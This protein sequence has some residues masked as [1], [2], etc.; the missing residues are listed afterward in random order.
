MVTLR[1]LIAEFFRDEAGQDLAEYALLL[2]LIALT[3]V[4]GMTILGGAIA[5]FMTSITARL[6]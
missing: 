6:F 1:K 4:G 5:E 2:S 3:A